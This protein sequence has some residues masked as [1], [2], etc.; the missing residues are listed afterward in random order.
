[1]KLEAI[2]S[3]KGEVPEVFYSLQGE[4]ERAGFPSV[5]V[6]FAGCNLQCWWCDTPYTWNWNGTGFKHRAKQKYAKKTNVKRLSIGDLVALILQYDRARNVVFTGGEPMLQ[7]EIINEVIKQ[8]NKERPDYYSYEIE[9][10]GTVEPFDY[11]MSITGL[12]FNVSPKLGSSNMKGRFSRR[13]GEV[14]NCVYKFVIGTPTDAEAVTE[15]INNNEIR[16]T[17]VI[18]MPEGVTAARL[19]KTRRVAADYA[20]ENGYR[21]TDRSHLLIWGGG[22]FT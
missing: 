1:M 11:F 4:G 18:V 6:R 3:A 9:T 12:T 10:N 15:F 7:Q 19:K 13:Y 20:L 8:L 14:G 2:L 16:E 21:Y 22:R 17:K 5:F